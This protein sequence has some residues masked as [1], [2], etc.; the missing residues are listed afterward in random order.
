MEAIYKGEVY[1]ILM[2]DLPGLL[3]K[4]IELPSL[5]ENPG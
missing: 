4:Q 2:K 5:C 3:E 1:S